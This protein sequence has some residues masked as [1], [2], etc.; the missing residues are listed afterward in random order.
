[1]ADENA[2][3]VHMERILKAIHQDVPATKRILELNPQ[4]ELIAT[5]QRL[6]DQD[7]KHPKV[8]EYAEL[9]YDQA[10]LTSGLPLDDPL[11]F[12]QRVSVLMATEGRTLTEQSDE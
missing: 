3:G 9:L 4:H 7:S 11:R 1:M 8:D 12:A 5:M 2:I 10:L 6:L